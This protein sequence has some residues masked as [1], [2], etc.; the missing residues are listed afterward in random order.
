MTKP[1]IGALLLLSVLSVWIAAPAAAQLEQHPGY[2][3]HERFSLLPPESV[4]LE[5]N[6]AGPMLGL[7]AAAVGEDD[8][9][10]AQLVRGL[11]G[12]RVRI[13]EVSELDPEALRAG[14]REAGGWL[15]EQGWQT[16][17][18][19]REDDEELYVYL[20]VVDGATVG[21]TV[22][23]LEGQEEVVIV[24]V[25]GPLDLALLAS[26]ADSLDLP[27]LDVRGRGE[28]ERQEDRP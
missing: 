14:F 5:V 19:L 16:V 4:S 1:G 21:A 2:F 6:L 9:A 15:G 7:I 22:M 13:A 11:E 8:P 27:Q 18:R 26:L 20:R 3:P 28:G 12:I 24:N 17:V 23:A 25:V 10:F